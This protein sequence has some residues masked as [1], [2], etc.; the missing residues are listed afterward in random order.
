MPVVWKCHWKW[1][2]WACKLGGVRSQGITR[3]GQT[4]WTRLM[5]T[6]IWHPP[7]SSGWGEVL[8]KRTVASASTFVWQK[9]A[10]PPASS[11]PLPRLW[12]DTRKFS[13]PRMSLV[14][15]TLL[16]CWSSEG[17]SPCKS[18]CG[19]FKRNCLKLGVAF[20]LTHP[21]SVLV[22][23]A[24][25]YGDFSS[26]SWNCGLGS[27][28]WSW[29]LSLLRGDWDLHSQNIPPDFKLPDVWV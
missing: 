26:Q 1:V 20:C 13:P 4:V 2:G 29:D 9:A 25:T 6:G 14:S 3:V 27:P 16:L 23:I 8:R 12:P 22:F 7:L 10:M 15:F 18:V 19:P 17:V 28:V 21:P 11:P 24:R 5:E